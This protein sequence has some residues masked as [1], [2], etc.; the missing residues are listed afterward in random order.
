MVVDSEYFYLA[1]DSR[2]KCNPKTE[3]VLCVVTLTVSKHESKRKCMLSFI[4]YFLFFIFWVYGIGFGPLIMVSFSSIQLEAQFCTFT[5][6]LQLF[7]V[8]GYLSFAV[9]C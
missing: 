6:R 2:L 1:L 3:L 5:L 4:F 9:G 7:D 8:K